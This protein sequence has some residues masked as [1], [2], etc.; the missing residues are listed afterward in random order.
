MTPSD[1]LAVIDATWAA[2]HRAHLGEWTIRQGKGGGS[3]VSSIAPTGDPGAP[4]AEAIGKAAAI[5]RGWGQR[6][7]FQIGPDDAALDALLESQGWRAED[8]SIVYAGVADR[9]AQTTVP[10]GVMAIMV[11]GPLAA[12]DK[13]WTAGGVGPARRA[14][15]AATQAR[16]ETILLRLQDRAAAALFVACAGSTAMLHAL[17]VA[18]EYRRRGL[19]LAAVAA[20]AR[21]GM[22]MGATTLSLAV[23]SAN[24][25]ARAL[26]N[27]MGM[28]EVCTYHYRSEPEG[29]C[30]GF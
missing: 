10:E 22:E 5:S 24:Q 2:P 13:L 11:R 14:V 19:G 1:W 28:T 21:R 30:A 26:Y 3:R 12:L 17:H 20:A 7:L 6:P 18:P 23:T 16:K 15:M 8:H 25:P 27:T 9:L 4:L 29:S